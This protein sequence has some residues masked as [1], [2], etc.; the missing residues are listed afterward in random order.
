MK[1]CV[2][3]KD[4]KCIA[5]THKVCESCPF[6]K[7]E[8]ELEEGRKKARARAKNLPEKQRK[9]IIKKYY[10]PWRKEQTE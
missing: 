3:D 4:Y 10:K 7:T 9:H 6:R 8:E 5:L 2:F 1:D